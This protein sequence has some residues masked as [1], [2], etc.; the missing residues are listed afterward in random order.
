MAANRP[1]MKTLIAFLVLLAAG[2]C[3]AFA[4]NEITPELIEALKD[5]IFITDAERANH[6]FKSYFSST[7]F[8]KDFRDGKWSGGIE[9]VSS[10]GP[11]SLSAN[12]SDA[13]LHEFQQ[14]ISQSTDVQVSKET[15]LRLTSAT[16]NPVNLKAYMEGMTALQGGLRI[17]CNEDPTNPSFGVVYTSSDG[18]VAEIRKVFVDGGQILASDI[19]PGNKLTN[20]R[21]IVV[22]RFGSSDVSVVVSTDRGSVMRVSKGPDL[23]KPLRD[24]IAAVRG[25]HAA[26]AAQLAAVQADQKTRFVQSGKLV[27]NGPHLRVNFPQPY[28]TAPDVALA[29]MWSPSH[30]GSPDTIIQVDATGF[31]VHGP[32]IAPNYFTS[33]IA[34]G[35]LP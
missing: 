22:R 31:D 10:S 6:D 8:E 7:R 2:I 18:S 32:N 12:A 21:N 26:L 33:W 9:G 4:Q 11:F 20:Q 30:V 17:S 1:I 35:R 24:E 3:P 13:S 23:L 25:A 28:A 19:V 15:L 27:K 34:V 29:T 5:H 16:L 14:R